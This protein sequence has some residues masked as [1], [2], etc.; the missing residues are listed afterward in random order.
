MTTNC[1]IRNVSYLLVLLEQ[2]Y[3]IRAKNSEISF[4]LFNK[5]VFH[6][7]LFNLFGGTSNVFFKTKR[8]PYHSNVKLLTCIS[9]N[10][11]VIPQIRHQSF[12]FFSLAG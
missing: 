6:N 10:H 3:L 12:A 7:I 2:K 9:N 8:I 4:T 1:L 11:V 5:V